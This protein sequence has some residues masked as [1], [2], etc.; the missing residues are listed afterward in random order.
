V[1]DGISDYD[2]DCLVGNLPEKNT[3]T[4]Q[5]FGM[6]DSKMLGQVRGLLRDWLRPIPGGL[7][8]ILLLL[9]MSFFSDRRV[10]GQPPEVP[11]RD[12]LL[13]PDRSPRPALL[14]ARLPLDFLSGERVAFVGNSLAEKMNLYGHFETYLHLA[15]PDKQLMVRNFAR[16]ADELTVR[17]RPANYDLL[18]DPL[19]HFSPDTVFCFYGYNESFAGSS[20]VEAFIRNYIE[21]LDQFSE[22]YTRDSTGAK[23]RFVLVGPIA[24]ED[25]ADPLLPSA[26]SINAQLNLYNEA[27]REVSRRTQWP[28]IDLFSQ[29][30]EALQKEPGCQ[31][32]TAGFQ[33]NQRGDALVAEIMAKTLFAD[34]LSKSTVA[35]D[36]Q[37][38]K[39]IRDIVNEKSWIHLQDYRMINGWYVYGGRRTWDHETFPREYNKIRQMAQVRDRA[40]WDSVSGKEIGMID[41][42][43]TQELIVPPTRFG[44]PTQKYSEAPELRYLSPDEFIADTEVADGLEIRL[45]ADE[46]MVPELAKPVQLNFD[47]QGRLW[48][49]CMPTYPQ[50]R[51]GDARPNDR[52]LILEDTDA[53][54]RADKSKVFYD[55][56]HCPTGFEFYKG[57]VLVVDQPRLIWLKDTDGDD[58]A[59]EVVEILDGW[60]TDDTHHTIGAFEFSHGG[61]LHMLEGVAMSTTLETPWGPKRWKGAAGSYVFDP[62]TYEISRFTTP[63]YGNPWCMLFDPWGQGIVGDGTNAQQHWATALSGNQ[64]GPRRGLNAI[65]DNQGMRPALGNE[66]LYSR[67]LPDAFQGELTYAC[68]INM[69]GMPRFRIRDDGAGFTGERVMSGPKQPEDLIRSKDKNFRPADPQ[70]GPDGALWFGDWANALIGHMQYSQRDPNRD[71]VRGRIYRLVAKDRPLLTPLTQ[72]GKSE[73]E[74]LDQLRVYEPRTRAKARRELADRPKELVLEAVAKWTSGLKS[75]L[76]DANLE[77]SQGELLPPEVSENE[78]LLCEAFWVYQNH[79]HVDRGL[80]ERLLKSPEP[81]VRAAVVHGI[82]DLRRLIPDAFNDLIAASKDPHPR[83]LAEV[84]RGLSYF[85]NR[86]SVDALLDVASRPM[87]PW[88]TYI[89]EHSIAATQGTWEPMYR[90]GELAKANPNGIGAIDRFLAANGP[91]IAAEKHIKL[92]AE[93]ADIKKEVARENAYAALM[94]LKGNA[95]NGQQVFARVCANCHRVGD[96]GYQFGPEL[97]NV[98]VRLNRHDLIESIVDPSAKMDPKYVTEQIRTEDDEVLIGFISEETDETLTLSLPEGKSKKLNKKEDIAER[99]RSLQSS[100]PESLAVTVA[101]TEFLD[102]IE[103]LS[104]LK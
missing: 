76:D 58:V 41:D 104:S 103:Y 3:K 69:N 52:L 29:S 102:L 77:R 82:T 57:G 84:T 74:L 67:H 79:H 47:N 28:M 73:L 32:T 18:D 50:W 40:I 39:A 53:D 61:L 83:V 8:S 93:P 1:I 91:G 42:S 6:Q 24:F 94:N 100:M 87:D 20:G 75:S 101:P 95:K 65:F 7:A 14:P 2:E 19:Y 34:R 4:I 80:I 70:I 5:R 78:R 46:T 45:F 26:D 72:K 63:G 21:Y 33:V 49:A 27:I 22:R 13:A 37:R 35:Q 81:R 30:Q 44:T 9:S 59:D 60:G 89:M 11:G 10:E 56:L 68:V 71:H 62:R 25:T 99:K 90:S 16:P 51:P 96:K 12:L 48:V 85:Q 88:L 98:A 92:L 66:L 31:Y 86:E 15:N 54:G 17:Q 55:K 43:S 64:V 23:V 38:V 97:T 36:A